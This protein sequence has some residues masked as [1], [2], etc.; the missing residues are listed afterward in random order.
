MPLLGNFGDFKN[1]YIINVID[2]NNVLTITRYLKFIII[3][4]LTI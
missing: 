3:V 1:Y 2:M 4:V